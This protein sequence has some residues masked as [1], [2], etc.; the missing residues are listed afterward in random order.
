MSAK[1]KIY[2]VPVAV[3]DWYMGEGDDYFYDPSVLSD[4]EWKKCA[5]EHGWIYETDEFLDAWNNDIGFPPAEYSE[6]RLI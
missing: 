6:L 5:L 1:K 3:L 2:I 4:E